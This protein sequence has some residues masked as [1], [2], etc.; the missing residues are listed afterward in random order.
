LGKFEGHKDTLT[1]GSV[2]KYSLI[3]AFS[4]EAQVNLSGITVV[5]PRLPGIF[6]NEYRIIYGQLYSRRRCFQNILI[7]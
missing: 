1:T 7:Y 3:P 5:P 4:G 2:H 6:R